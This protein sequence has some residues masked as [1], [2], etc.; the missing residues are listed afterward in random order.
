MWS[1]LRNRQLASFKFRRQSPIGPYI[2]D[3]ECYAA[4]LAVELDGGQHQSQLDY[5][6]ERT[7][8]MVASGY[9]MLRFWNNDVIGDVDAVLEVIL[10]ALEARIGPSP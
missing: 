10:A 7:R 5:D 1:H 8:Y 4:K 6:N 3:F 2:A 9:H